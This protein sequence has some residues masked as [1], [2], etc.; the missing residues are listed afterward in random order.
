LKKVVSLSDAEIKQEIKNICVNVK[1]K[2]MKIAVAT[3]FIGSTGS[4]ERPLRFI[5]EGGF[6]HL[7]WCHQWCT[8]FLYSKYEMAEYKRMLKEF[9]LTLLDIHG[10]AG[11]EKLWYATEEYRRKSGVELV[12]NRIEMLSELEAEEGGTLMMHFPVCKFDSTPER[13]AEVRTLLDCCKR[14]LDE[15]MPVLEKHNRCIALENMWGDNW[16]TLNEM[17]DLYPA[18][19]IG[20]CYDSGHANGNVHKQMD[21]L[22]ARKDRLEALHLH[23]NNG[24]GD[25]HQ[26]P[27]YGTVDWERLAQIIGTSSYQT[28]PVSFELSIGNTPAFNPDL[29]WEAQPDE[30]VRNFIHD[31]YERCAKFTAMVEQYRK[32]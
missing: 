6:T 15:I 3:D 17:L 16:E 24:E 7:H 26:P 30:N 18:E 13:K 29:A 9:G 25:Q 2:N 31:A 1:G 19:R 5:A 4:P 14:S 23:D 27:F 32:G 11:H 21:H 22:E 28:R 20:I 12:I 10:S 8:D